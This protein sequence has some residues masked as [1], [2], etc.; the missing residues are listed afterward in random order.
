MKI[1]ALVKEGL[2]CGPKECE[3]IKLYV[4]AKAA[5]Q[6]AET[7]DAPAGF[8]NV[9]ARLAIE[10]ATVLLAADFEQEERSAAG[11]QGLA[12]FA[13]GE[14]SP[15]AALVDLLEGKLI[16]D[17]DACGGSGVCG[18]CGGCH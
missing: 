10:G 4:M 17:P 5:L 6:S 11:K 3:Q 9:L 16:A 18:T 12:L 8:D 13:K 7:V 15:G 14:V 1:A 2:L